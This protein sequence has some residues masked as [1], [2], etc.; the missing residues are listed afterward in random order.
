MLFIITKPSDLSKNAV[1]P[2]E[3]FAT[4]YI[5][6]WDTT[7][8]IPNCN[9]APGQPGNDPWPGVGKSKQNGAIWGHWITYT[10]PNV[11]TNNTF[12]DPTKFGVCGTVL[13]R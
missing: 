2:I 12:C 6:G 4:F 3:T 1:V 9:P 5:T 11:I 10:D 13:T 7:G 8:S